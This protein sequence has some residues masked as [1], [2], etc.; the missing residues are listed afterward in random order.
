[1]QNFFSLLFP[2]KCLCCKT[3]IHESILCQT[4]YAKA[5]EY[6]GGDLQ[7]GIENCTGLCTYSPELR[8]LIEEFKFKKNHKVL[9]ILQQIILKLSPGYPP[10]DFIVPVPLHPVRLAERGFNQSEL[11]II[12]L[13]NKLGAK[14]QNNLVYHKQNISHLYTMSKK[15][16]LKHI[17]QAYGIW[18]NHESVE[19][20]TIL[21][22]DD[23][24]TTGTTLKTIYALLTELRPKKIF[25]LGLARTL[26]NN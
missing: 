25:C 18:N 23:I 2:T 1:M 14:I 10:V 12:P 9:P 20:K 11:L 17:P 3:P 8:T 15:D 24:V 7:I 4:C 22:F 26:L 6:Y 5:A 16:R 13:A 19:G 21:V